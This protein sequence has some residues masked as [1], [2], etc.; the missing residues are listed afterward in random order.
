MKNR[1]Q[2]V[3]V[4]TETVAIIAAGQYTAPSGCCVGIASQMQTARNGTVMH[5]LSTL[6]PLPTCMVTD[7]GTLEVTTETTFA[8]L[9]RLQQ[10]GA[11]NL[12]CLNFASAKNPGG[13]FLTGAQAQEEALARSSGLYDCLLTQPDYYELNRKN[14]SCLYLDLA[15]VSPCVPFIRNDEGTL[16]EEPIIATV[17][18]SPAPN[19]GAVT[20]NEPDAV[21][22]IVPTLKRRAEMVLRMAVTHGVQNLVLGAWGCGVFRNDPVAVANAFEQLLK[23]EGDYH[24]RFQ[25]VVFAVYTSERERANFDA[26]HAALSS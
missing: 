11:S 17:I 14:R 12:G 5:E 24:G 6:E 9:Q 2:R 4:A 7:R 16:L 25:R 18:T 10:E 3:A 13:G 1:E 15:I 20:A 19:A 23:P 8:A 22:R 26:F 21:S